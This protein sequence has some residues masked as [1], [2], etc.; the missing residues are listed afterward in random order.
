MSKKCGKPVIKIPSQASQALAKRNRSERR[1]AEVYRLVPLLDHDDPD[2]LEQH[3]PDHVIEG[4]LGEYVVVSV[5][6]S[7]NMAR[8]DEIKEQVMAVVKRP[9]VVMSHNIS[10]LKAVKLSAS[11]AAECIRKG[12]EYAEAMQVRVADLAGDVHSDGDPKAEGLP[13]NV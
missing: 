12:E 2:L 7:C 9:V 3:A 13:E 4:K 6:E 5:P 1:R 10:L 11:E 8:A